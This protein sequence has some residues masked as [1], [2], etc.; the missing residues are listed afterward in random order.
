MTLT[1]IAAVAENG[2]IGANGELAWRN[3][4]DLRRFK[5]LT[6]GHPLVMGRRTYE[7]IGRPLP[8]RRTIVVTRSRD[9]TA[10]GV[11]VAHSIPE[12]LTL[13]EGLDAFIVG[14]GDIY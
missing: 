7:S 9:W 1:L 13:V 2:V 3:S 6:T 5:S 4:D 8:G 12:A 14:G 10:A 11:E